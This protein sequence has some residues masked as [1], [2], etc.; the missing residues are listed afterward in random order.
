MPSARSGFM[1]MLWMTFRGS[2]YQSWYFMVIH[3]GVGPSS[4]RRP[5]YWAVY[6]CQGTCPSLIALIVE[7]RS[8][9]SSIG[10]ESPWGTSVALQRPRSWSI[11][12]FERGAFVYR[13]SASSNPARDSKGVQSSADFEDGGVGGVP[14]GRNSPSG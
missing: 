12:P 9:W 2:R 6:D 10:A 1:R 8:L 5:L 3:S 13:I 11:T 14:G 4:G 7:W